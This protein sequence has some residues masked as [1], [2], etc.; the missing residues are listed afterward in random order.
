MLRKVA[1]IQAESHSV[2]ALMTNRNR[3]RVSRMNGH[4]SRR[5]SGRTSALTNPRMT[6]VAAT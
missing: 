6:A 4:E 2:K 3:P 5:S 1:A